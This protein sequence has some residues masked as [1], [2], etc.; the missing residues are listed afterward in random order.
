MPITVQS[1]DGSIAILSV[2]TAL[3]ALPDDVD[4][5]ALVSEFGRG[6]SVRVVRKDGTEAVYAMT[7][8]DEPAGTGTIGTTAP[9]AVA[10]LD[11]VDPIARPISHA[12]SPH[13]R[14]P[15]NAPD[16]HG[17]HNRGR[18]AFGRQVRCPAD[19]VSRGIRD[20]RP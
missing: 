4:L 9:V 13:L 19:L 17:V 6:N 8:A 14:I 16:F 7:A 15:N 1:A 3:R 20:T 2:R 5:G 11:E 10:G 12:K 18:D